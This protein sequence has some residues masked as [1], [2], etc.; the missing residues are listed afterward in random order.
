M[1]VPSELGCS[2]YARRALVAL[3]Y[4][5]S[6]GGGA[7]LF[8]KYEEKVLYKKLVRVCGLWEY[9]GNFQKS[10]YGQGKGVSGMVRISWNE[11]GAGTFPDR[12]VSCGLL[13]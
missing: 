3:D 13:I 6:E 2:D 11:V 5:Y 7:L 10:A 1:G 9:F 8:T 4:P 12:Q